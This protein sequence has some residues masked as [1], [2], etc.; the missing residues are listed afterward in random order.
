[1]WQGKEIIVLGS[2]RS[3]LYIL[4]IFDAKSL[5]SHRNICVAAAWAMMLLGY[6]V[7]I[8]ALFCFRHNF[9]VIEVAQATAMLISAPVMGIDYASLYLQRHKI[10]ERY[11][12]VK[13]S[14][15]CT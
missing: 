4:N 10:N 6:A 8:W 1:M 11:R 9:D 5:R 3:F 2:F 12:S 13:Q 15:Q 14:D 7:A